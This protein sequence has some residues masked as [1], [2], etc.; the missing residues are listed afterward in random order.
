MEK[1]SV[2]IVDDNPLILNTLDEMINGEEGLSV[3]GKADNGE[4]AIDMIVDTTPDIV[5]LDLIM[6]KVDGISVVEKVK[7][8]KSIPKKTAFIF[9]SA[10]GGEQMTEEAFQAGANYY[11]M[12]P[13]DKEILMNKIRH[14]G[15]LPIRPVAGRTAKAA[16][17][18]EEPG[19][20][21]EEYI[22]EHLETDITKMLHELGIPAHIKGY[23]Y[24]R[25]AIAL[26][27]EDQEMIS[28]VTKILYPAIAKKNQTTSSRVERA[29]RH[30]IEVA[31]GRGKM[32]TI[33]EVFG[34]TVSTSKGKPTNSEFIA[35]IADKILL[36]GLV[37]NCFGKIKERP[38]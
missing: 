25:D 21:R 9:L 26:S 5:L 14:V 33:D 11:L 34:Y 17:A 2:A 1:L 4:D 22:R 30:A 36:P 31:W 19:V 6:P 29:I 32:E 10:V 27:V 13:F 24:L 8:R 38:S 15:R 12:K 20:S 16:L 28:S 7:S 23:Q 37:R 18:A 35:L 3:I